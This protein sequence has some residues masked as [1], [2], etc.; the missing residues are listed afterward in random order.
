MSKK[1]K[2]NPCRKPATQADVSKARDEGLELAMAI[3]L[4]VLC[5]KEGYD[6]DSMQR[7]WQE[8]NDLSESITKRYVKVSDLI[9]TLLND[10]GIEITD[11]KKGG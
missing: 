3:M 7:V 6:V 2:V 5:D 11:R 10:Y 9:E 8:V 4:S 1:T